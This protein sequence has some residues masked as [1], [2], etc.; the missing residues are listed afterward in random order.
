VDKICAPIKMRILQFIDYKGIEKNYFYEKT[1]ISASNFKSSGLKSEIGGEK[2]A[3]ILSSYSELNPEWLLTGS[4]EMLKEKM[5]G[6]S[7]VTE[8][9]KSIPLISLA[10]FAGFINNEDHGFDPAMIEGYYQAPLFD[11]KSVDFLI[12]VC[13][14]S[15]FPKYSNGDIVACRFINELLFVQWNRIYVLHT[16]SQGTIIKRLQKTDNLQKIIC[17][18]DNMEYEDF[19]ISV[20]DIRNIALVVGAICL[21]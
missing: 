6:V 8:I 9:E 17:H 5:L 1:N 21:G 10:A 16:K 2:I 18:S 19:E 15:M 13:D 7:L 3:K 14:S 4:G 20:N 11:G 12:Q